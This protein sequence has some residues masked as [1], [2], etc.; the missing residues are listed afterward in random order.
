MGLAN[1]IVARHALLL[2]LKPEIRE[3]IDLALRERERRGPR[4]PDRSGA[5]TSRR[6]PSRCCSSCGRVPVLWNDGQAVA[7]PTPVDPSCKQR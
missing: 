7:A 4:S 6:P 2:V 1:L 3:T 5:G